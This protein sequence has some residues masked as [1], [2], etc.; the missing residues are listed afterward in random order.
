ML[1]TVEP[2]YNQAVDVWAA[3]CVLVCLAS[4]HRLPYSEAECA[5]SKLLARVHRGLMRPTLPETE[6]LSKVVR[7]CCKFDPE[8]RVEAAGL[9]HAAEGLTRLYPRPQYATAPAANE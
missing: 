7:A 8:K 6:V 3:G 2:R 1:C 9:A 4:N 5:S